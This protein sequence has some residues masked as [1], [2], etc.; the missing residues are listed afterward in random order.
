[1]KLLLPLALAFG[2]LASQVEEYP[3]AFPREGAT[4]LFDNERVTIWDVTWPK[5][6]PTPMHEHKYDLV[7]VFLVGSAIKVTGLDGTSRESRVEPGLS[8]FQARGVIHIEEG[9]DEDNPR[10]AIV[11]DLKDHAT[12]PIANPTRNPPAFP[13]DGAKKI[14]ENARV[15]MWD[16]RWTVGVR[17]PMFFHDKDAVYV[18]LDDGELRST[19]PDG[20]SEVIRASYGLTRFNR[21]NRVYSEDL[22]SGGARAIVTELK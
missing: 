12:P 11:I 14:L 2:L 8:L 15:V 10:H 5:G 4:K 19:S 17:T 3:H 1:M 16:Y 9:L 13:R 22:M 18:F 6:E 7:G 21:R 20:E